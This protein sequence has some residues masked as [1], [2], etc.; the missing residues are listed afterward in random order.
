MQTGFR[1]YLP[2][3][4]RHEWLAGFFDVDLDAQPL[5]APRF[6]PAGSMRAYEGRWSRVP[7]PTVLLR[8]E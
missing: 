6:L 1:G 2:Y 3:E 8:S 7:I 4:L 5:D